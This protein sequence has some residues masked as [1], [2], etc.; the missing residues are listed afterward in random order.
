MEPAFP[1]PEGH[2]FGPT[3]DPTHHNGRGEDNLD[4]LH[5]ARAQRRLRTLWGETGIDPHGLYDGPTQEA[6]AHIQHV[7]GLPPTGWLDAETW[8]VIF[9][10][11]QDGTQT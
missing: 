11:P 1:L 7:S 10:G 4:G 2:A 9:Q 3:S 6:V 8:L 5:L